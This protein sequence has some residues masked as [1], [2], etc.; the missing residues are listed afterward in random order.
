MVLKTFD[1]TSNSG[2]IHNAMDDAA[3]KALASIGHPDAMIDYT[4]S[5]I[6]GRKG[7]FAGFNEVT[8]TITVD[9]GK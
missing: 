7:G 9:S 8:V 3:R 1:G 2:S 4:V 5:K 6:S